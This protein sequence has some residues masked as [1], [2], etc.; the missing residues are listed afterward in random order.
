MTA[1]QLTLDPAL[2]RDFEALAKQA[3]AIGKSLS[4]ALSGRQGNPVAELNKTLEQV[5]KTAGSLADKDLEKVKSNF[6]DLG[7]DLKLTGGRLEEFVKKQTEVFETKGTQAFVGKL[8]EIQKQLGLSNDEMRKFAEQFGELGKQVELKSDLGWWLDDRMQSLAKGSDVKLDGFYDKTIPESLGKASDAFA[9]LFTDIAKGTKRSSE[10]FSDLGKSIRNIAEE[11]ATDLMQ[12]G[13]RFMLFGSEKSGSTG[14]LGGLVSGI[15][16][17]FS[18]SVSL[19]TLP[20][21]SWSNPALP[22]IV[23]PNAHGNV[24]SAG[25]GLSAYRNTIVSRP[26]LFAFAK[27]GVPNLGLMGEVAGSPGEAVMPLTRASNGDLGVKASG[28]TTGAGGVINN[29]EIV[30]QRGANA[31]PIES[32]RRRTPTAA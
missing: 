7:T 28:D 5:K 16:S 2:K 15:G 10:L 4:E 23:W 12:V 22:S 3:S 11:I 21:I 14:L 9:D 17:L 18:P 32:G 27:G 24:F 8:R 1:T 25:T 30:D 6:R 19:P 13:M 26:T 29:F 20:S 31:P